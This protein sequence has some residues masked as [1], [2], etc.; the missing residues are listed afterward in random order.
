MNKILFDNVIAEPK[1]DKAAHSPEW[2][3]QRRNGIG[4]SDSAAVLGYSRWKSAYDVWKA[5]VGPEPVDNAD[6]GNESTRR[7]QRREAE[8]I[9]EYADLTNKTVYSLD[10][11]SLPD[12]PFVHANLDGIIPDDRVI[13]AKTARRSDGWGEEGTED[14][15]IDYYLQCQHYM[16]VCSA[17]HLIPQANPLCDIFVSIA[18]E[19]IKVY[20]IHG[21][22]RL[23]QAMLEQYEAFWQHVQNKTPPSNLT[24]LE[25]ID[26]L[27]RSTTATKF[28]S[29]EVL[30][31]VAHLR[32]NNTTIERLEADNAELKARL[33]LYAGDCEAVLR[34][35]GST[36]YTCKTSKPRTSIDV[37]RLKK[38]QPEIYASYLRDGKSSRP[39]RLSM[40]E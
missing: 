13:E 31:T 26:L 24:L 22:T 2:Y 38:E 35:D 36:L 28:A 3:E 7:G 21:N 17:L 6:A 23:W 33:L 19:A 20:T 4:G 16:L 10:T 40:D 34:A 27:P 14:I 15:P 39:I 8:I 37:E 9:Q 29:K 25:Q 32:R 12:Y 11:L 18:G 30:D 1:P 5:K